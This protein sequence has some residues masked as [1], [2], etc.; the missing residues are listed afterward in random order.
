MCGLVGIAGALEH[1]DERLMKNLLLFDVLRG[2]HSTGLA[3]VR[4]GGSVETIKLNSHPL[5]LF[6]MLRFGAVLSA[7]SSMAFIGHNRLATKGKVTSYNAH[8]FTFDH[9]TGAHN[10]TLDPSSHFDLEGLA[11]EKFDVDSQAIFAAIAKVGIEEV[12]KVLRGAYA[13]VWHDSKEGTLNFFR[14]KER[15]FWYGFT[16][17]FKKLVWASEYEIIQASKDLHPLTYDMFANERGSTYFATDEDIW[18]KYDLLELKEGGKRPKPV[19]KKLVPTPKKE[20]KGNTDPFGKSGSSSN[21][22]TGTGFHS[23]TQSRGGMTSI[24]GPGSTTTTSRGKTLPEV[25]ELCGDAVDPYGGV[26]TRERFDRLA[27][28]GCCWCSCDIEWGDLGITVNDAE[29]ILLCA[30]HSGIR[31]ANSNKVLVDEDAMR[32]ING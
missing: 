9:I 17:D 15:P 16:S 21:N 25:I 3:A 6:Q 4:N 28:D 12:S 31:V 22:G 7:N 18:Y 8:P 14:N 26:I 19:A 29:D 23:T 30:E 20:A 1:R 2:E 11:E 13:L 24:T 27:K 5:D 32:V 10:G